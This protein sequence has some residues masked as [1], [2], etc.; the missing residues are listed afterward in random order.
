MIGGEFIESDAHRLQFLGATS[1]S[2]G[3]PGTILRGQARLVVA[4]HVGFQVGLVL[5]N[6]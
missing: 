6:D 3:E 2:D 1:Q 4:S 5:I